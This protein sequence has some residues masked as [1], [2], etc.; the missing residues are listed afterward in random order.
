MRVGRQSS[1]ESRN[2]VKVEDLL[3]STKFTSG[4]PTVLDASEMIRLCTM[5]NGKDP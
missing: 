4:R 5:I 1:A 3:R 2:I